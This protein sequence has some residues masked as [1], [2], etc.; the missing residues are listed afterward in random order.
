MD[1]AVEK[2]PPVV[3]YGPPKAILRLRHGDQVNVIRHQ[4]EGPYLD[5]AIAA[6]LGHQFDVGRIIFVL[7][8]RLLPTVPALGH[9]VL[10]D[11]DLCVLNRRQ[12][13]LVQFCPF[14]G[15]GRRP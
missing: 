11:L 13:G 10:W 9:K 6:P 14:L 12:S 3:D 8:K 1:R 5:R 4:A 7:K 15:N 2:A